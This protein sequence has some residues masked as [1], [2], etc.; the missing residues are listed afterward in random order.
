MR[1]GRV[2]VDGAGGFLGGH[3]V[4]ALCKAGYDVRATDLPGS[5]GEVARAAGAQWVEAD[6]LDVRSVRQLVDGC[7]GVIHVA[8]LFDFSMPWDDL[9]AANVDATSNLCEA[10]VEAGVDKFVHVSSVMV[11]GTPER[12]PVRE[13]APQAPKNDYEQTKQLGEQRVWHYQ[14]FRGLPATVVRPAVIYGPRSR[15]ILASVFAMYALA[16]RHEYGW[17]RRLEGAAKCHH[18][19][20]RDVAE[21]IRLALSEVQT[22]GQA[23]NVADKTPLSWGEVTQ[24][25]ASLTNASVELVT[26]PGPLARAVGLAGS[27]W[28]SSSL[29]DLNRTLARDWKAAVESYELEHQIS[30]R[31]DRDFFGYVASDHVYDIGA[32][33]GLGMKFTYPRTLDGLRATYGWYRE[34][35]WLP[36]P[37]DTAQG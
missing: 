11:H 27:L 3:V 23:Y 10:A 35:K 26:L 14:R 24:Y 1:E 25:M 34:N 5:D 32:L 7:R 20:V 19:H 17:L 30:P 18:V 21:A 4:E 28:P 2:L 33:E 15:Y 31:V 36:S 9:Y 16:A 12:V 8:G 6:L 37:S 29:V 22:I 13:D